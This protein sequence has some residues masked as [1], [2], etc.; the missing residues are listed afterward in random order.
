M[1]NQLNF[2]SIYFM[3]Y[4]LMDI[5]NKKYFYIDFLYFFYIAMFIMFYISNVYIRICMNYYDFKLFL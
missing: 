5:E 2:I 3:N 4:Y 1:L